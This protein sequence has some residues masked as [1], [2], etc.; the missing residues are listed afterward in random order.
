MSLTNYA[1]LNQHQNQHN[2]YPHFIMSLRYSPL[3]LPIS[4]LNSMTPSPL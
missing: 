3:P 4:P 1:L 2:M